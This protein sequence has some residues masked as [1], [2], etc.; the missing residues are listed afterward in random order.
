MQNFKTLIV[1]GGASGMAVALSL[2]ESGIG[3]IEALPRLGKKLFSTGNGKCNLANL[4]LDSS[5][6]ND[7]TLV[8][9]VFKRYS[10]NSVIDF[11]KKIGVETKADSSGRIYPISET[12]SSVVD[13]LRYAIEEKHISVFLNEK[14]LKITKAEK[15]ML[16]TETQ[17]FCA[18][19]VII[20]CGSPAG[21]FLD[22]L[23]IINP[24][25]KTRKMLPSLTPLITETKTIKGLKG[26]RAKCSATLMDG[27]NVIAT[28]EGEVQ[29]KDNGLSGIAIFNLSSRLLGD[30]SKG[31]QSVS[32][33]FLP[34]ED[35]VEEFLSARLARLG[36]VFVERFFVGLFH[37]MVA[38]A[39]IEYA[40]FGLKETMTG[41]KIAK[42][43][44]AIKNFK[45]KIL[46][47]APISLA[48][49]CSGGVL[50]DEIDAFS[51]EAKKVKGLY[52]CGEILD[53]D[54][55]CGGYNLS[56]AWCSAFVVANAI[57]EK[58]A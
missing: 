43:S 13:S 51:L 33:N 49:V 15:F 56:W 47:T 20:C 14:V 52:F 35:R 45:V 42:L 55:L 41:S 2:N 54:G 36:E 8:D 53:V 24:F 46:G 23:N 12:S 7:K 27:D 9:E 28:E 57:N 32:I 21:G 11:F 16:Y 10:T 22:S 6:F 26:V 38:N 50:L 48:Q 37:K 30:V 17:Q 5:F 44:D 34:T 25:V 18:D 1:G 4:Q 3:I 29:F 31:R 40:G 39:I 19:K 58:Q